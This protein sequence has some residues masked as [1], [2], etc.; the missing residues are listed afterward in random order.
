MRRTCKLLPKL[1]TGTS[2]YQCST[3][4]YC[5]GCGN[6]AVALEGQLQE[7]EGFCLNP[8]LLC[9]PTCSTSFF[10]CSKHHR[11]LNTGATRHR[12][13]SF[14]LN[15]S[16][17]WNVINL[18]YQNILWLPIRGCE[19]IFG[20][21]LLHRS[22]HPYYLFIIYFC[23]TLNLGTLRTGVKLELIKKDNCSLSL[24]IKQIL[25]YE[26]MEVNEF[27]NRNEKLT[28]REW[29][30]VDNM[31]LV[32]FKVS[33]LS[34]HTIHRGLEGMVPVNHAAWPYFCNVII[35]SI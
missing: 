16:P 10:P 2:N 8:A 30:Y 17:W 27:E 11:S 14:P 9:F 28:M 33:P 25:E 3:V 4:R 19:H 31:N 13:S 21:S 23:V 20:L 29:F 18:W 32:S 22:A 1:T 12:G 5:E 7:C 24:K 6:A 26:N 34:M 15:Q 35:Y